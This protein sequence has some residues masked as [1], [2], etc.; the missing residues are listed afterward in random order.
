MIQKV[1]QD[2][3]EAVESMEQNVAE[4]NRGVN[5]VQAAY[6]SL[7]KIVNA[8]ECSLEQVKSIAASTEQ[9]SAAVEEISTTV[10]SISSA[11]GTSREAVSQISSSAVDLARVSSELMEIVSWFRVDK[12]AP[13]NTAY[14]A[15]SS[16]E[17]NGETVD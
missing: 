13:E 7:D 14:N 11:F 3:Y 6:A 9:Q 15:Q 4:A 10:E 1:Q 12:K 16:N 17:N 8:S 5:M 2:T